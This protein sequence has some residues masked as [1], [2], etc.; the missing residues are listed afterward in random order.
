MC[1]DTQPQ[2]PPPRSLS[3]SLVLSRSRADTSRGA[4]QQQEGPARWCWGASGQKAPR[5]TPGA[6]A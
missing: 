1:A 6:Q 2:T 3:L 5:G 4:Q